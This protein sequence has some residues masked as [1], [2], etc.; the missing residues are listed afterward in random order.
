[1]T[2]KPQAIARLG[3][4]PD[5]R[6]A[7]DRLSEKVRIGL[8][9]KLRELG[10]NPALGKPLVGDLKGYYRITYGCLR[11]ISKVLAPDAAT[12][13]AVNS[14][15]VIMHVLYIGPRKEGSAGDPYERAAIAALQEGDRAALELLD[16]IIREFHGEN[17]PDD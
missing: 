3:F 2:P 1:M 6:A 10:T 16:Q 14:D 5:A 12:T 17:L 9:R 4:S 15:I 11:A 7:F 13:A 8:R